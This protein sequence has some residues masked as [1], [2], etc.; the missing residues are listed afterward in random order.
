[1]TDRPAPPRTSQHLR[2][3]SDTARWVAAHRAVETAR[4][5]AIF[6]DPLAACLAGDTGLALVQTLPGHGRNSWPFVARTYL[7]DRLISSQ[8]SAGVDVIINLAAGLDTRPYRMALPKALTWVEVDL[9]D[10]LSYKVEQLR[11]DRPACKL[12]RIACDLSDR[13]SRREVIVKLGRRGNNILVVTEGLLIYLD[14][15]EVSSLAQDLAWCS[16]VRHWILDLV[17]PALLKRLQQAFGRSLVDANAPLK[18]GPATGVGFFEPFGW[19]PVEAQSLLKTAKTLKRLPWYYWPF[20][21]VADK[22]PPGNVPWSGVC[23]MERT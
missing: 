3:I 22:Q 1:M 12:E 14:E 2:N 16:S 19:K 5:D 23:L 4:P 18:F 13:A 8:V 15:A 21:L 6:R 9:P 17:S 11:S 10:L 20:T 7:I